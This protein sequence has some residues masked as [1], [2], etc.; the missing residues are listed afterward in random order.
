VRWLL[1]LLLLAG[2][3]GCLSKSMIAEELD[4]GVYVGRMPWT[5]PK[6]FDE[7]KAH[8]V[9]TIV[10]LQA[11]PWDVWPE[12]THASLAGIDFIDVPMLAMPWPPPS[13]ESV[14]RVLTTMADPA[15]QPVFL[16]CRLGTD[17]AAMIVGLYRIYYLG[18]SPEAAWKE[19]RAVHFQTHGLYGYGR[20]FW[21]H[22]KPPEWARRPQ[23][24]GP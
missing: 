19:M 14:R 11:M 17:R 2:T 13:E 20:Y 1:P 12:E 4:H 3:T 21:Q 8:G 23:V 15:R 7:L 10:S 5:Y 16:H 22:T 18:W 6:D 9:R 24:G